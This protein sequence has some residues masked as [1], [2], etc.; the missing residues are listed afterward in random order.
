LAGGE[1]MSS[2]YCEIILKQHQLI[3]TKVERLLELINKM[4]KE[5]S[6]INQQDIEWD[7]KQV[8]QLMEAHS[9]CE[10]QILLPILGEMYQSQPEILRYVVEDHQVL[11]KELSSLIQTELNIQEN[12]SK[13]KSLLSRITIHSVEEETGLLPLVEM[14]LQSRQ[15]VIDK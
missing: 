6:G 2:R 14:F 5:P 10:E 11:E 15:S 3:Q 13:I 8:V 4:K 9:I 1:Q 12:L 7:L